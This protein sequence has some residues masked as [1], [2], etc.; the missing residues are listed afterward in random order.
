[1]KNIKKTTTMKNLF[2]LTLTL[3]LSVTSF[4]GNVSDTLKIESFKVYVT[5][6]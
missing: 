6:H 2:I 1:M 3:L 4:A 5:D